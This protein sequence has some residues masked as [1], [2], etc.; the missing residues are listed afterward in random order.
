MS[1]IAC[2]GL[3]AVALPACV[4]VVLR[5]LQQMSLE[6]S[7]RGFSRKLFFKFRR[8]AVGLTHFAQ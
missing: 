4:R 1:K 7:R 8:A 2:T 6:G 5:S 3:L